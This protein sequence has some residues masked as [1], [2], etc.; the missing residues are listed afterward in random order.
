MVSRSTSMQGDK[1]IRENMEK[2][3]PW[4]YDI[5]KVIGITEKLN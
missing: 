5:K 4:N 1:S 3:E 2:R